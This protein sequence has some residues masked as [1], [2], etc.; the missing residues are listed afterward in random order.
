MK[1]M[2]LNRRPLSWAYNHYKLSQTLSLGSASLLLGLGG[3]SFFS[4]YLHPENV[5]TQWYMLLWFVALI[6]VGAFV[7]KSIWSKKKVSIQ[8]DM[9]FVSDFFD[10]ICFKTSEISEV[11]EK[12]SRG[13]KFIYL[14][15]KSASKFG[16]AI[17]FIPLDYKTQNKSSEVTKELQT[18]ISDSRKPA[19]FQ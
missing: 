2:D 9:L 18:L 11:T 14:R 4:R 7:V 16:S 19:S 17:S 3:W 1:E 12:R 10:E 5:V 15:L 6:C 8:G 13:R